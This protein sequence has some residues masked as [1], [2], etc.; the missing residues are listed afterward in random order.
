M[1]MMMK[2]FTLCLPTFGEAAAHQHVTKCVSPMTVVCLMQACH[3][4]ADSN[5]WVVRFV[6]L[7][8]PNAVP[9]NVE[10]QMLAMPGYLLLATNGVVVAT[11]T[12][13]HGVAVPPCCCY[14]TVLNVTSTRSNPHGV[15]AESLAN[16]MGG[17]G[18]LIAWQ[19]AGWVTA[20]VSRHA[21]HLGLAEA[22]P[23][24]LPCPT[25]VGHLAV[26]RQGN[27]VAALLGNGVVAVFQSSLLVPASL[28][29][30][31]ATGKNTWMQPGAWG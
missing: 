17:C 10:W 14:C 3:A 15:V 18:L 13:P 19:T 24:V 1:E 26:S 8:Q 4:L 29:G 21:G 9:G 6:Q 25:P 16:M 27:L 11:V 31:P 30:L 7:P 20:C 5:A 22:A 2:M 12:D 23:G 28:Q